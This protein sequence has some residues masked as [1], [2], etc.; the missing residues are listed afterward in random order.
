MSRDYEI[1]HREVVHDGF[2]RVSRITLR[3]A[4]F[5][6]GQSDTLV[7]E[8]LERG[9]AV[10]VLPYDPWLDR[11][12]LVEQFR[13]GAIDSGFGPW[14]LEPVAG[15]IE[16][17]EQP[18]EVA[19]RETRE[20]ADCALGEL[21]PIAHYLVSPG[22]SSQ[23]VKLYCAQIDS[24]DLRLDGHGHPGENE[25]IRLHIVPADEALAMLDNGAVSA[26]MS[27]IA[28]QWLALNRDTLRDRWQAAPPAPYN[29]PA[30]AP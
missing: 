7:R 27:I 10:G 13:P 4:L 24:R 15:I 14:L 20:E 30:S 11:V 12:V 21:V 22:G 28:L 29:G 25:D 23:T 26:V 19:H 8:R 18:E 9:N 3:H 17:G 5:G 16:P 1:V 2:F 6:G